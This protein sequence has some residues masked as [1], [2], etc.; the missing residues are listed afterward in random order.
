MKLEKIKYSQFEGKPREWKIEELEFEDTNLLVGKNASGKSK[1]LN[2]IRSLARL[3]SGEIQANFS[4]GN[5]DAIFDVDG[6]KLHYV[7]VYE[8]SKIVNE[9]FTQD[10]RVLLK[11]GIGGVGNLWAEKQRDNI[12]FQTPENQLASITRRDSIQHPFFEPLY[13]WGRSLSYLPFGTPLGKDQFTIFLKEGPKREPKEAEQVVGI[14]KKGEKEIGDK[15]IA[16]IKQGM[17]DIG[18]PI[19]EVGV[20][21][22]ISLN[23]VIEAIEGVKDLPKEIFGLCVKEANL[24]SITDQFDMSQGMFRALSVIIHVTYAEMV[25][26]PSCILIDDIGEGL[27]FDRSSAL[28]DLLIKRA[29]ASRIQMIMSTNDRFVMNKVPLKTWTILQR[30]GSHIRAYNYKNSKAA[31]D[32]FAVTGLNNFDFFSMEFVKQAVPSNA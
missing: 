10:G 1:I 29:N 15:F 2:I 32:E 28:I 12:E 18:Y 21:P 11:R 30:T 25:S 19:D 26:H 31:F 4:S 6:K 24:G 22:P 9:E 27:D 5:Y 17:S 3:L 8:N 7:L 20:K 16:S 23:V 13:Q 14:F